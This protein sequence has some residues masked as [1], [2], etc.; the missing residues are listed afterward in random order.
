MNPSRLLKATVDFPKEPAWIVSWDGVAEK[1]KS[2]TLTVTFTARTSAPL[3]P[4]RLTVYLPGVLE[5]TVSVEE[6]DSPGESAMLAG[7]R[8]AI[9]PGAETLAVSEIVPAKLKLWRLIWDWP[10]EPDKKVRLDGFAEI[11]KLE[12]TV[13]LRLTAWL[14]P[15]PDPL[16]MME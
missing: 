9:S 5:V 15:F 2:A 10:D 7:L 16:T 13:S 1:E 3:F 11:M 14:I 8:D 12:T 4:N 6:C